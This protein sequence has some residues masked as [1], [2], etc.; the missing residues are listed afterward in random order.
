MEGEL[1]VV[2]CS[3]EL[4]HQEKR[5]VLSAGFILLAREAD[6]VRGPGDGVGR[7]D[8]KRFAEGVESFFVVG[9][10]DEVLH[11][12]ELE[13]RPGRGAPVGRGALLDSLAGVS[14]RRSSTTEEVK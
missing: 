4:A 5:L 6:P 12:V 3:A 13:G 9:K 11:R 14:A 2:E 1:H 10:D 7:E 8:G